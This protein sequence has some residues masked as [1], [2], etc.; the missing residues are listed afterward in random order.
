[1]I[2]TTTRRMPASLM[3][4]AQGGRPA[5]RA[6][7][8]QRHLAACRIWGCGAHMMPTTVCGAVQSFMMRPPR[9]PFRRS[10][11]NDGANPTGC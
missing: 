8:F 7:G 9:T 11:R 4:S 2:A 10:L 1:L 3:A 6:A 5:P